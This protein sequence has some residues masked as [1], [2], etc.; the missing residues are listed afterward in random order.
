M[1]VIEKQSSSPWKLRT[2]G[3]R[4]GGTT[5]RRVEVS[6]GP[7]SEESAFT[8]L[9]HSP[10]LL[11]GKIIWAEG[12]KRASCSWGDVGYP[13]RR[14]S[15]SEWSFPWSRFRRTW[16]NFPTAEQTF[17]SSSKSSWFTLSLLDTVERGE[18]RFQVGDG[19]RNNC[20]LKANEETNVRGKYKALII[21]A[22]VTCI[23]PGGGL[24]TTSNIKQ[25]LGVLSARQSQT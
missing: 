11:L 15:F 21:T 19:L 18:R 5:L 12:R 6:H 17:R 20:G 25:S 3:A 8:S 7:W 9:S 23:Y 2:S 13:V 24:R 1:P 22:R 14:P 4:S 10:H 16:Q